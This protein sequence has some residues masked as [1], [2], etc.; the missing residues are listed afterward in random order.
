MTCL[1]YSLYLLGQ[2]GQTKLA[3][4]LNLGYLLAIHNQGVA[5]AKCGQHDRGIFM[6]TNDR[7]F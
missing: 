6:S 1:A 4:V 7:T 3:L 2:Y 5:H